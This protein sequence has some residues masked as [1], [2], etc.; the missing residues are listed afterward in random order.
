VSVPREVEGDER[1]LQGESDGVKGV[2]VLCAA[3][4][5][6]KIGFAD[7]PAQAA[8]LTKTVHRDEESLDR[9]YRDVKVPLLNILVKK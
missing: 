2:R 7:A 3:M 5:Q 8:E 4:N 1:S 6:D 9:R